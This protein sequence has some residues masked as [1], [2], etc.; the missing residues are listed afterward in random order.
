[1]VEAMLGV[2]AMYWV[3]PRYG[4]IGAAW[5]VGGLMVS[6]R[7]LYTPWL[8]CRSLGAGFLDYMRG[9]YLR[10]LLAAIPVGVVLETIKTKWLAGNNWGELILAGSLTALLFWTLAWFFFVEAAHR[11]LVLRALG[12]RL[13][14]SKEETNA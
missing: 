4:I 3:L 5:I 14:R 11:D 2:T 13:P 12:W 7:G 6:V 1:M 8:V 9:I 10:P